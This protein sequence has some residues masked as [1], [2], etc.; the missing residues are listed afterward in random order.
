LAKKYRVELSGEERKFLQDLLAAD[1]AAKHKKRKARILLK[2]D[3]GEFGTAWTDEKAADAFDCNTR[4]IENLRKRLVEDGFDN[5]L[6]HGNLNNSHAR[7]ITGRE[8]ALIIATACGHAPEGRDRWTVRLLRD[9]IVEMEA[10]GDISKS[11]VGNV[12]KKTSLSLI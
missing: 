10:I 2:I 3:Q 5:I 11:T 9:K 6:E 8:E 12:L 7:K 1:K 4:L